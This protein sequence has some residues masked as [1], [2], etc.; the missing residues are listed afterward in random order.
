MLRIV[1]AIS[2]LATTQVYA[3]VCPNHVN[4]ILRYYVVSDLTDWVT[5]PSTP[6]GAN[7]VEFPKS[8]AW[9]C[10]IPGAT[11]I[12]DSSI[13]TSPTTDQT[14]NYYKEFFIPG[15]PV[16]GSFK[17]CA[18]NSVWTKINGQSFGCDTPSGSFGT[19]CE[20]TCDVLPYLDSGFN[21]LNITVTNIG[22]SGGTT[23][24]NP[25][26]VL[27]K[28]SLSYSIDDDGVTDIDDVD[29]YDD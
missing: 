17:V 20:K 5:G 14:V 2:I 9:G 15:I 21:Y 22:L 4:R 6:K 10:D 8:S 28:L 11:W 12:W 23:Q 16:F 7:A 1:L 13:I 25:A 27:Y 26:G 3:A 19:G 18:D 29:D 24:S